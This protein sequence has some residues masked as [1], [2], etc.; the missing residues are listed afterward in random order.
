MPEHLVP[1]LLKWFKDPKPIYGPPLWW[2]A[3]Y[4]EGRDMKQVHVDVRLNVG[5]MPDDSV[6]TAEDV[7]KLI[8]VIPIDHM[9]PEPLLVTFK[10]VDTGLITSER[11]FEGKDQRPK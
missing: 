8:E 3:H 4:L 11:T 5:L 2:S 9:E 7:L 6:L 10:D 1:A